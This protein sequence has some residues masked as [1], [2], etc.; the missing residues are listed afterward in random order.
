MSVRDLFLGTDVEIEG[1]GERIIRGIALRSQE[2]RK[3]YLFLADRGGTFDGA[4]FIGDAV[5]R[6][7]VAL[8][9]K[10]GSAPL[11]RGIPSVIYGDPRRERGRIAA[12]YFGFPSEKMEVVGI[13]GTNG[14]TTTAYLVRLFQGES[15]GLMSTIETAW[16]AHTIPA[17]L[18]TADCVTN[19]RIL[20]EMVEEK[21]SLCV[22]EVTSHALDQDRV[23]GIN[24][25][26]ALFTNFSRDHLDYHKSPGE[27]LEA[28]R[29]LLTRVDD[30]GKVVVVNADDPVFSET[31]RPVRALRITYG[32]GKPARFRAEG[33]TY[34]LTGTRFRLVFQ[35][36]GRREEALFHTQLIGRF[37][38]ENILAA[39]AICRVVRGIP[40]SRMAEALVP[41]AGPRGRLEPVISGRGFRVL[42]DFAHTPDALERVL[43]MLK[44]FSFR[45]KVIT[46]FGAGGNRDAGKR[47][48]MGAVVGHF[49]DRTIITS[50]NPRTEDPGEICAEVM[51]GVRD[52]DRGRA[53]V[54]K[55]RSVAI[56]KGIAMAEKGDVVLIAGRG[57]E[58]FQEIGNRRIPFEDRKVVEEI[59]GREGVV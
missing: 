24:F 33:I 14:K 54:E 7:A 32:I 23:E 35:G 2:V 56:A 11:P 50:D 37:N 48:E 46:I 12:R 28:K 17:T 10:K 8:F 45:G 49:S 38:V 53:V 31:I 18:T 30:V 47:R 16:G 34:S 4:R 40:L 43:T 21:V 57:H 3:D 59:L 19:Q 58:R 15:V 55:D 1:D 41:F 42:I 13:T 52:R 25:V 29:K 20:R 51:A 9:M 6:G 22:M 39:V 27:Y 5:R 26:A 36:E 44:G